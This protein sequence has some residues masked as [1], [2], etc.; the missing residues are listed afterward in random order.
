M[1]GG[2]EDRLSRWS[3]LKRQGGAVED[4]A[5]APAPVDAAIPDDEDEAATLARLDLPN[6]D[7]LAPGDDFSAFMRENVPEFLRRRALRVLWRSNP[8]L[9]EL[10]GL[11]DY[12]EDFTGSSITDTIVQTTY[13]VGRGFVKQESQDDEGTP[14]DAI[15]PDGADA[16]GETAVEAENVEAPDVAEASQD[17]AQDPAGQDSAPITPAPDAAGRQGE[18]ARKPELDNPELSFEVPRR[19]VFSTTS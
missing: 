18:E 7:T 17:P 9:A 11:L 8:A 3:R 2:G 4:V 12:G 1:T 10:D 14:D 5:P 15:T 16:D 19:M 6:P 13:Q